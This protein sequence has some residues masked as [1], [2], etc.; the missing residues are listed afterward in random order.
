[1]RKD[2]LL[3]PYL[4]QK[5]FIGGLVPETDGI[6]LATL[7]SVYGNIN[8]IMIMRDRESGASKGFAFVKMYK[9]AEDSEAMAQL[10]A[11]IVG[12]AKIKKTAAESVAVLFVIKDRY[13]PAVLSYQRL[14]TSKYLKAAE[15]GKL[16]SCP[17][18]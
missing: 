2:N 3:N 10:N 8:T 6:D 14:M 17:Y 7:F 18:F 4:T 1:L 5:L 16:V 11:T 15:K 13:Q 9:T 12:G